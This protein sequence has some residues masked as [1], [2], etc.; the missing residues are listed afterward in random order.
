MR[1]DYR[2]DNPRWGL[3]GIVFPD[4]ENFSLTLGF[5]SNIRHYIEVHV[6][7]PFS[8]WDNSIRIV[9]ERNNDQGAWDREG[10]IQYFGLSDALEEELS[11][12][13][14]CSSAGNGNISC[15]I[16]SNSF[17]YGLINEFNFEV[18][19][20]PNRL[21]GYIY[22]PQNAYE[23]IR[24]LLELRLNHLNNTRPEGVEPINVDYCLELFEQGFNM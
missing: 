9:I 19:Q 24:C 15:R 22:P 10:R 7:E 4:Y 18:T 2:T 21:T 23:S 1:L 13:Y 16:N 5:L 20:V 17:M 11:S 8:R 12:L 14:E 3:S 6:S